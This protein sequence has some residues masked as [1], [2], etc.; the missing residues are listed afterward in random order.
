MFIASM[1]I[2]RKKLPG[3]IHEKGFWLGDFR[4]FQKRDIKI[5]SFE[6][7]PNRDV[8][9]FVGERNFQKM[10]KPIGG[11]RCMPVSIIKT[12]KRNEWKLD[13]DCALRS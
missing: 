5:G 9:F 12:Q 13:L 10:D 3:P 8:V 2:V 4:L 6:F 7:S 1:K 11:D